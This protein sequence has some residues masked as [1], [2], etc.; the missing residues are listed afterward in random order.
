MEGVLLIALTVTNMPVS[1]ARTQW[2]Q[3]INHCKQYDATPGCEY[4]C[5]HQ[6]GPAIDDAIIA[7]Q[8]DCRID[9]GGSYGG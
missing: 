4:K 7:L 2:S 6:S 9:S 5:T 8:K 3:S 1:R